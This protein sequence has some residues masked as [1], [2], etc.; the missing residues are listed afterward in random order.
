MKK[1]RQVMKD[2]RRKGGQERKET[3]SAGRASR[4]G[5]GWELKGGN[6]NGSINYKTIAEFGLCCRV[7]VRSG[8]FSCFNLRGQPS[9]YTLCGTMETDSIQ[10]Y[11]TMHGNHVMLK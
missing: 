11:L 7:Q 10:E 2:R 1:K 6:E 5:T 9:M 8:A 4:R 3:G